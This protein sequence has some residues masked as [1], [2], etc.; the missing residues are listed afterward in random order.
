MS[1]LPLVAIV[2]RPNVGKSTLYN[3]LVGGRPALVEDV[4]GVT[5]DRRYGQA[6]FDG[7]YFRIVDTGGMDPGAER[8]ALMAGVHK[9][10]AQAIGEADVIIFV[11][12]ARDG[13]TPTDREVANIL[14][15]ADVPVLVVA[16]KVDSFAQE[17]LAGEVHELG[18]GE[19]YGLSATHGRGVRELL[20]ALIE[21]LPAPVIEAG[22]DAAD[23]PDEAE[24]VEGE[25]PE[26]EA[27]ARPIRLAFVGRPNVG[28]SSLV[29][30]LLG[31]DR[32]LVHDMPGTTTDPVDTPFELFG[33]KYI[34]VDTAGIR[35]RARIEEPTE[36]IS[37]SMA[38]SQIER[39]DV[40]VLVID[41]TEGPAEQDSRIAGAAEDSGRGLVIVVNKD[42]LLGTGRTGDAAQKKLRDRL[43]DELP[44][45]SFAPI[46]FASAHT[47]HGV[48][49]VISTARQ[50][51]GEHGR[52]IPTA[53][54]NRFYAEVC[55]THP[56]PTHRGRAV[57]VF[58]MAQPIAHPPT[59]VLWANKP[60]LVSHH[61]RRF[62][63]NQLRDRFGFQGTPLRI[64]TRRRNKG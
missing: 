2:G 22:D 25:E 8:G 46:R 48:P 58:Y 29:N 37:V 47:G 62:L 50:V 59:F 33:Q 36:K 54:L 61:Y 28:K 23:E 11:T 21:A 20:D 64:V 12:D 18:L 42:D 40:A 51:F 15:R 39:C 35:R 38:L 55:E 26:A 5:R 19:V 31:E 52:R 63:A 49:E 32:V 30:R 24:V 1:E 4:P 45:V 34:L 43:R 53:E 9:Q 17:A 14:R 44:F 7:R 13:L 56:P 10:A 6:D 57:R 41:G 16:N 3:R 27:E 60:E